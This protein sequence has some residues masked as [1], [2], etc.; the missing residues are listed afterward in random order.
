MLPTAYPAITGLT[1]TPDPF[2]AR[3]AG[4]VV[5]FS[6]HLTA[7][8][9]TSTVFP[10][11][12]TVRHPQLGIIR[13]MT[14]QQEQ[15]DKLVQ[16]DGV[17]DPNSAL[18]GQ[19]APD[20]AY[21]EEVSVNVD[22]KIA[23]SYGAFSLLRSN[24]YSAQST[25][26]APVVT[27]QYDD[28]NAH[29]TITQDPP[30]TST[31]SAALLSQTLSG[32]VLA[33]TIFDIVASQAF[34]TQP[35]LRFK[36]NPVFDG[37]SLALYKYSVLSGTWIQVSTSYTVDIANNEIIVTLNPDVFMGSL[38]ALMKTDDAAAPVT[39][40]MFTGS[41]YSSAGKLYISGQTS[42]AF[43]PH[44][45]GG[46]G[47][48]YTQYRTDGGAFA[49]YTAPF[50]MPAG[51]HV[52]EYRS[53]DKAGNIED[54][55]TSSIT[56][57][58]E[59]PVSTIAFSSAVAVGAD[60]G[61]SI[62][63][64][65][66]VSFTAADMPDEAASLVSNIW[67]SVDSGTPTVF[68]S[69]FGLAVGS[70]TI[71]YWSIDNLGNTEARKTAL[72]SVADGLALA[73]KLE[74]QPSTLNLNSK[75][76]AV[77]AKL[78]F[79]GS[80]QACF[81]SKTISISAINGR[82]LNKPIYALGSKGADNADHGKDGRDDADKEHS[83][84]NDGSQCGSITVKFDR[85]ALIAVLPPNA[86]SNV[87]VSGDL[88]DGRGFS[89]SDTIR[90][91]KPHKTS[92][93]DGGRFEHQK[94]A[95]FD[96]PAWALKGDDDLY[97]LSVEGDLGSRESRKDAAAKER[98]IARRGSAYEF[99]PEGEV[100]DKPVT[101][102]LPYDAEDKSSEKLAIAYWN[103]PAGLW[104]LLPSRR[105]T[106]GRLVKTEVPHFS[107]YQVVLASYPISSLEPVKRIRASEQGES[108]VSSADTEFRLGEVYVYPNPA[109]GGK[110][111]TFHVEAGLADT[112]K[113]RVY[114]VAGQLVHERVLTGNPQI[115]GTA[116][117]YEY[118]WAGRIASGVYYYNIEAEKAGKKLNAKG[119]FA[120]VR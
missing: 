64:G 45:L 111:P 110:V 50:T 84:G 93:R 36:Y 79:E 16:W 98:G 2:D 104:E 116:Y 35:V 114:T 30:V 89:A 83:S 3:L 69:A 61:Y 9:Q 74:L 22:G 28:P 29:V 46:S 97:V 10:M 55:K 99:G 81:K 40:L 31:V 59:S 26:T 94:H 87:T 78:R 118:F 75:G 21:S 77:T 67:Y 49:A 90:T 20:G 68:D 48:A 108:S 95:C 44:D 120:V 91:I 38:F 37:E 7:V 112:V 47:V 41:Q 115:V 73:V 62:P 85:D 52:I 63:S 32:S 76:E 119:K 86:V 18:A 34:A 113:I 12:V 88:T 71:S 39:E 42:I 14:L 117:A 72:V 8:S 106:A 43:R 51:A 23:S 96:A 6:Y 4:S 5:A 11:T 19:P 65:S 66:S 80:G 107:Q 53:A 13:T 58:N 82:E 15:G 25:A 102:S 56:V 54:V 103:E 105:D 70:Y 24:V 92:R 57:D 101:I 109:K 60:G 33:S 1:E 100:F 27:V 17:S